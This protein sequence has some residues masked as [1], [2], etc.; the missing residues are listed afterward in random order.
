M[1]LR[2]PSTLT[3]SLPLSIDVLL[4]RSHSLGGTTS[5]GSKEP[6]VVVVVVVELRRR[7]LSLNF[8]AI[9]TTG[10]NRKDIESRGHCA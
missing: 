8:T 6:A 3:H 1:I 7:L 2:W 10:N 9:A 5:N 4:S